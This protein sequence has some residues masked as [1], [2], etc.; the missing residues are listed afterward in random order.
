MF[1]LPT[2]TSDTQF[3]C[4]PNTLPSIVPSLPCQT[5]SRIDSQSANA[6]L[7]TFVTLEGISMR[8]SEWQYWKALYSIFST[9]VPITAFVMA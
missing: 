9:P 5:T 3:V 8:S 6:L 1:P 4:P 2:M 7:P